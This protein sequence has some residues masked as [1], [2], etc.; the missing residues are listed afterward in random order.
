MFSSEFNSI[1][2]KV[3]GRYALFTDPLTKLGG[4]KFSYQIP[5]YEALRGIASSIYWKPTFVW[6]IDQVRVMKPIQTQSKGIKPLQYSGGNTL[7][8]YTYL[9][10]VEYQVRARIEWNMNRSDLAG[11]RN[12]GKHHEIAKRML[13]LCGRRDIY[14]GTRE[15]QGYAEP[16]AFGSGAGAFDGIEELGAFGYMFHSF[17]YPDQSGKDELVSKFWLPRMRN[18]VIRFDPQDQTIKSKTVR[19][20]TQKSFT[21][22]VNLL[23]EG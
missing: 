1:E 2:F 17:D 22:G 19:P 9:Y 23:V 18:G 11:D 14:L 5:T 4:E 10:D 12:M 13:N 16:C 6:V 7:A 8:T 21:P 20:M 3:W 15:C